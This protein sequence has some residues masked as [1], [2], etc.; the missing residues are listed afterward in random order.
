MEIDNNPRQHH[1]IADALMTS[2]TGCGAMKVMTSP[3]S[4]GALKV[5][6]SP[7]SSGALKMMTSPSGD[8][9]TK[10]LGGGGDLLITKTFKEDLNVMQLSFAEKEMCD[11][12]KVKA[13]DI[14]ISL[15]MVFAILCKA[16]IG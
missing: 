3:S 13:N 16:C 6:T 7:S 9:V 11:N 8:G 10:G 4:S 5:M 1:I 15:I 14:Y 2:P 12:N